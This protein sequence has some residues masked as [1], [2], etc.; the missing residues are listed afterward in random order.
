MIK[1]RKIKWVGY[2]ARMGR[3]GMHIGYWWESLREI[4]YYEDKDIGTWIILSW[5]MER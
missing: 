3:K 5:I 1:S 4:D 2:V